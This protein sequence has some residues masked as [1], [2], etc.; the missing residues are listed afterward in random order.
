MNQRTVKH[1][2]NLIGLEGPLH[3]TRT[4]PAP[5]LPRWW[6]L[7]QQGLLRPRRHLCFAA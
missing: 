4:E 2:V 6:Q 7:H 3:V 5:E 1:A